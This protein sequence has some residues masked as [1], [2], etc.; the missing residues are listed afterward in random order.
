MRLTIQTSPLSA[1]LKVALLV[2]VTSRATTAGSSLHVNDQRRPPISF[3][4]VPGK[5]DLEHE[6]GARP[7]HVLGKSPWSSISCPGML[8]DVGSMAMRALREQMLWRFGRLR[9]VA[10][11]GPGPGVVDDGAGDA[12]HPVPL[13]GKAAQGGRL[14]V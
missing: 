5:H 4:V 9:R 3:E 10:C 2:S 6:H 12:L 7:F 8:W 13:I 14:G 1:D 11:A